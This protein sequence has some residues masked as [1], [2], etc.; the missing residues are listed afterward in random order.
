MS[1]MRERECL[2][3]QRHVPSHCRQDDGVIL[4]TRPTPSQPPRRPL[5][6]DVELPADR[7][8]PAERGRKPLVAPP[9]G[10]ESAV[11]TQ[12][13][14]N[15][16]AGVF[17]KQK[18]EKRAESRRE[19]GRGE[20]RIDERRGKVDFA[21]LRLRLGHRQ[22]SHRGHLRRQGGRPLPGDAVAL[23]D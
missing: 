8:R 18:G 2:A 20:E 23:G 12:L 17:R 16:A 6:R 13:R 7:G 5:V 1:D 19:Q 15:T 21:P 3:T 9:G 4:I 22:R 11:G 14:Q 10:P